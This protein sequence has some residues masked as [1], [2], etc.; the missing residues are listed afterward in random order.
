MQ[1]ILNLTM[2]KTIF[3]A[4]AALMLMG[5]QKSLED[6]AEQEAR[7]YTRKFCPTP[8]HNHTRTD[9]LVFDRQSLTFIYYC[10]LTDFMDDAKLIE[11]NR[12]MLTDGLQQSIREST[13]LKVYKDAGYSFRYVLHSEKNPDTILYESTFQM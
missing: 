1:K 3:C 11:E 2:K 8:V 12:Q 6:R 10:T 5:C 4:I 9:S 13:G 7:D